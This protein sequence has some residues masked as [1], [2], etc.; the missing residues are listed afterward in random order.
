MLS[1]K[2][3]PCSNSPCRNHATCIDDPNDPTNF[4]C[5][6]T[7]WLT[8]RYCESKFGSWCKTI[9]NKRTR[10]TI[11]SATPRRSR[12][13]SFQKFRGFFR[14][15]LISYLRVSYIL[16]GE[17]VT[18]CPYHGDEIFK[19]F[20]QKLKDTELRPWSIY[21]YGSALCCENWHLLYFTVK[22]TKCDEKPCKDRGYC[23]SDKM[24]PSWYKCYCH[25]W[26]NG[27]NCESKFEKKIT[28]VKI[29]CCRG[30]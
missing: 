12:K 16:S 9:E 4:F 8:G 28:K 17:W 25:D 29:P 1:E 7:R 23:L 27:T 10:T 5:Q 30:G 13:F 26:F 20:Y 3:L 15:K 19:K 22:K 2:I 6:C 14:C 24:D 21:H 11:M 18:Y